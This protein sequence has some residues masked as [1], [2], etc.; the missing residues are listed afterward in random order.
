MQFDPETHLAA[1]ERAVS[2]S[3]RDGEPTRSIILSRAYATTVNDLWD[4]VTT[5]ERIPRWFLPISGDLELGGRFQLEGNAGGLIESC[6]PPSRYA[7]TWEFGGQVSWVEVRVEGR[8][9]GRS[10]LTLTHTAPLS[11]QWDQYGPGA[12]GV[13]W[14]SGLLGLALHLADPTAPKPDPMVFLTSPDGRAFIVASSEAWAEASIAAGTNPEA[15]RTAAN[16]TTAFY[17]GG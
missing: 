9:N 5:P 15:A 13:G 8:E 1:V 14:D 11:D 2:A 3:E 12:T 6:V 16:L 10:S 17:T 4:A 7:V